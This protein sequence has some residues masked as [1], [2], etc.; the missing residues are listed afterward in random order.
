[1]SG[2]RLSVKRPPGIPGA[3][4]IIPLSWTDW[5]KWEIAVIGGT[6]PISPVPY[7][8]RPLFPDFPPYFPRVPFFPSP[9]SP[10]MLVVDDNHRIGRSTEV[11]ALVRDVVERPT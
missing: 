1:M 3:Q 8:R 6:S 9:I 2:G 11:H 10:L 7:F 5:C 4:H